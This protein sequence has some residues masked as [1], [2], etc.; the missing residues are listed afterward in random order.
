[1]TLAVPRRIGIFGGTF[2]PVHNAHVALAHTALQSLQLDQ[3]RWV[4][5]GQPWQKSRQITPAEHRVAMVERAIAGEPRYFLERCEL[6]RQGP[7]YMI[8]TVDDLQAAT[9]GAKWFLVIGQDQHA[10]LHTWHRWRELL[11]KVTLAVAA[12]PGDNAPL[13]PDVAALSHSAVPLPMMD[14]SSTDIRQRVAAGLPIAHL[15]P[16]TVA[17]YIDQQALYR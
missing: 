13:H 2:D 8:D 12:R 16:V 5:T 11:E 3:L 10:G 4:P 9:P 17:G 6:L 1:M 15:V 14:I 7:S